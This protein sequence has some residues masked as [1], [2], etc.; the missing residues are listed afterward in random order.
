[1]K[2]LSI[3]RLSI[4]ILALVMFSSN[5]VMANKEVKGATTNEYI[6]GESSGGRESSA[7]DSN[8][9]DPSDSGESKP[10]VVSGSEVFDTITLKA[11]TTLKDLRYLAY[12]ISGF[13]IIVFA[14]GAIFG[15]ISWKHLGNIGIGLFLIAMMAPVIEYFTRAE[16]GDGSSLKFGDHLAVNFDDYNKTNWIEGSED[17]TKK[18][19]VPSSSGGCTNPEETGVINTP[20]SGSQSLSNLMKAAGLQVAPGIGT[21]M[22][23]LSASLKAFAGKGDAAA[24]VGEDGKPR[25]NIIDEII[26][27]GKAAKKTATEVAVLKSNAETIA[28]TYKDA[29]GNLE[30]VGGAIL[31]GDIKG[32]I[33]GGVALSSS[34]N[35]ASEITTVGAYGVLGNSLPGIADGV[36][37]IF[38]SNETRAKNQH[39]RTYGGQSTNKVSS[40]TKGALETGKEGIQNS[41]NSVNNANNK[42][43]DA[44]DV[45]SFFNTVLGK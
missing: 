41:R 15:K 23:D 33:N 28:G 26:G 8:S 4:L 11:M 25:K 36:Q 3:F 40:A 14:Y 30:D 19:C 29:F 39:E 27:I 17:V 2:I 35:K 37:D 6:E 24:E 34:V 32:A 31:K 5:V 44:A 7:V 10:A 16:G 9:A 13:G 22:D 45:L 20:L 38:S 1:M 43:R 42:V 21:S 18:E 12:I